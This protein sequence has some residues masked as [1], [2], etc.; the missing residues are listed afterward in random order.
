M[1]SIAITGHR[2]NKLWGY[3]LSHPNYEKLRSNLIK[4]ITDIWD[5][6][7]YPLFMHNVELECISGMALG[8]DTVFAQ[9]VLQ[10]KQQFSI[11][12]LIAA[13]PCLNQ[14]RKWH[15]TDQ[16]EYKRLLDLADESHYVW[17][18]NYID[19][20]MNKRNQYM[21]DRCNVLIAVWNGDKTGGT[22]DAIRRAE[23]ADKEI[24]IINPIDIERSI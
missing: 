21:I 5:K 15:Y 2:P 10:L 8:V 1:I 23:K 12:K 9:A 4:T 18:E 11:V 19:G 13:I 3:D 20:C 22:A 7:A 24:I 17:R 14:D 6:K 16:A